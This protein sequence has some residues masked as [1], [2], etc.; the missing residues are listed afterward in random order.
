MLSVSKKFFK[1]LISL[2]SVVLIIIISSLIAFNYLLNLDLVQSY[3][4]L[5]FRLFDASYDLA[6]NVIKSD[7]VRLDLTNIPVNEFSNIIELWLKPIFKNLF[8]IEYNYDTIPKYIDFLRTGSKGSY[9]FSSPNSNLFLETTILHG[10]IVGLF[11]M[12]SIVVF[13]AYIRLSLIHI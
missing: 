2:S 8:K 7:D 6:F 5:K 12:S 13:G 3:E 11:I 10:R 9:G 4:I 1:Q